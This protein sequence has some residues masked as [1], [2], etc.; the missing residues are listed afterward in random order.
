MSKLK[1]RGVF[2]AGSYYLYK[3]LFM[4]DAVGNKVYR[5]DINRK[6][7]QADYTFEQTKAKGTIKQI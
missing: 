2:K 7:T 1:I 5:R 6:H 3:I 4:I